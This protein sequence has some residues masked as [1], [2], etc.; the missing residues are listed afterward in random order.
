M[1]GDGKDLMK[2]GRLSGLLSRILLVSAALMLVNMIAQVIMY[3]V[4]ELTLMNVLYNTQFL[5][6]VA[7]ALYYRLSNDAKYFKELS[8]LATLLLSFIFYANAWVNV[9]YFWFV[10]LGIAAV[11]ADAKLMKKALI[12]T[13]FLLA[14]AQFVHLYFAEPMMV[15]TSMEYAI[16]TGAYHIV[17]YVPIAIIL[18]YAVKR[19]GLKNEQSVE[20]Q[21]Q[22]KSM[23]VNVEATADRLD[24]MVSQ[25]T[26]QLADSSSSVSSVSG[27]LEI[28]EEASSKYRQSSATAEKN[29]SGIVSQVS[30]VSRRSEEMNKLTDEVILAAEE[31]KENLKSTISQMKEVQQQSGY[32]AETVQVLDEKTKEIDAALD[33]IT[34]IAAQTNLLALNA[35]IEAARAG[36][37]GKGFAIVADEVRKLAEQSASVSVNIR[38]V[39]AEISSAKEEVAASLEETRNKMDGSMNAINQT[40]DVF[41]VLIGKQ[42]ELKLQFRRILEAARLS[43]ESGTAVQGTMQMMQQHAAD[44]DQ[45][46]EGIVHAVHELETAFDEIAQFA[47]AVKDQAGHLTE[48]LKKT[49]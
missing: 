6:L 18:L 12:A 8:V 22:L 16:L 43:S 35:S 34:G 37:H 9:P 2:E 38:T 5:L 45:G 33:Q 3:G 39:V 27:Q 15:E 47:Y 29:V 19:A 46:I 48:D 30:D 44:N 21:T 49:S 36:E 13:A 14:I 20:L 32:S 11:Y 28:M 23:L 1:K 7:P 31:N 17:Q 25:L 26:T 10:P 40:S 41:E 42:E 4:P 24:Q